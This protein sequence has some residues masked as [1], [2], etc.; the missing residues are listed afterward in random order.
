MAVDAGDQE[1]LGAFPVDPNYPLRSGWFDEVGSFPPADTPHTI[2]DTTSAADCLSE[3]SMAA[4]AA[5]SSV[6]V[7]VRKKRSL[8]N[9]YHPFDNVG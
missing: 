3:L 5:C 8:R 7:V 9:I 6:V 4:V 2:H 1:I